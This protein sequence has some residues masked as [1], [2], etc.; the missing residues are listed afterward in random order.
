MRYARSAQVEAFASLF[1]GRRDVYGLMER[2]NF[3]AVHRTISLL[4]YRLHLEGKLRLGIYPLMSGGM[5]H[6]LV[7]DFDGPESWERAFEVFDGAVN[8]DL[9]FAWEISRSG[10]VHLWLFFSAPASART[11]RLV[12]RMLLDEAGAKAEIFPKQ[13]GLPE[14]GVGNSIML[15]LSGELVK[16]GR[17]LFVEPIDLSPYPDQLMYLSRIGKVTPEKLDDLVEL[18]GLKEDENIRFYRGKTRIF[19]GDLLPCAKR[20]LEGV[21]EGCRDVV[22]FR[23]AIHLKSR[24]CSFQEAELRLQ[25]WNATKNRSPLA[26]NVITAKVRSAYQRGYSGYGCEDPLIL[27]FC[28]ASCPIKQKMLT[29]TRVAEEN[30]Q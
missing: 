9:P 26:P 10:D 30:A 8:F 24:G 11:A 5:I 7:L 20:M 23:L 28:D 22:A 18:N 13:D 16:Q 12:A 25:E 19:S 21:K 1:C 3:I 6:F 27:P 29:A 2:G 14:G 15:P 17:T 4:H